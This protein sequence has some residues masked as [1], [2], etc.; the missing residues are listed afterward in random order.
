V[1]V[2]GDLREGENVVVGDQM[3]PERQGL[4]SIFS[5]LK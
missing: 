2:K 5:G 3:R 4:H 1:E